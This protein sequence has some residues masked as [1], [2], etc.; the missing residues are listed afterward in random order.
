[1]LLSRGAHASG[2]LHGLTMTLRRRQ[3]NTV[4]YHLALLPVLVAGSVLPV[5]VL[6]DAVT[7]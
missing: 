4:A 1:M 2:T 7:R 6:R 3:G 5:R